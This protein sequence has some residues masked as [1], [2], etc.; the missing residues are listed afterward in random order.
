MKNALRATALLSTTSIIGIVVG[1][2]SAKVRAVWLGPE[3][4]GITGLL[5]NL[6]AVGVLLTSFGVGTALVRNVARLAAD[7]DKAGVAAFRGA[8]SFLVATLAVG[9]IV[10]ILVLS[11]PISR[12]LLGG[13]QHITSLIIVTVAMLFVL[14]GTIQTATLN[15]YH[16][17]GAL[18]RLAILNTLVGTAVGLGIILLWR[19]RGIAP[20]ILASAVVG[21]VLATVMVRRWVPRVAAKPSRHQFVAAGQSL[22]RFGGPFTASQLVGD[23]VLFVIPVVVLHSL[24]TASVAFYQAS[25]AIAGVYLGFLLTSM[26]QDYYP[27][28]SAA[29]RE[30]VR[31]TR[32]INEQLRLVMIL[33]LP[34]ILV[35]LAL[36][37]YLVPLVY[38]RAFG[39]SVSVLEW[40]LIGDFFRFIS[41]TMSFVVLACCSGFTFFIVELAG[42]AIYLVASWVG[43]QLFGLPGL[44]I[45]WLVVYIAYTGI[46]WF[47][48]RR[49][50]QFVWTPQNM[51]M[52][53]GICVL[54]IVRLASLS[55][56]E[57]LRL[58]VTVLCALIA[59]TISWRAIRQEIGGDWSGQL[60]RHLAKGFMRGRAA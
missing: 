35:V 48:V 38:S 30:P 43:I 42:G 17:V 52:M 51:R 34:L 16:R 53:W 15:A 60:R 22:L 2:V 56:I 23:G 57:P 45:G 49:E 10:I 13:E 50:I 44:G 33:S 47:V 32:L 28:V 25:Y 31:L 4:V 29:S 11:G 19:T 55:G 8:G 27:R 54:I 14:A 40:Q 1:L 26:G 41:W 6:V 24:G 9:A 58:G 7:K 5:L 3:G 37:P 12:F 39:P 46:V 59:S 36:A 21:W 18:A 20:A